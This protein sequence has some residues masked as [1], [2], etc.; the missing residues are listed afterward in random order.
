MARFAA[1]AA[2]ADERDSRRRLSAKERTPPLGGCLQAV[3]S[4]YGVVLRFSIGFEY[5]FFC[6]C[7]VVG[8]EP[9]SY[10]LAHFAPFRRR[11]NVILSQS[12]HNRIWCRMCLRMGPGRRA[13]E[14]RC[15]ATHS[16]TLLFPLPIIC[17]FLSCS[18]CDSFWCS[19]WSKTN[20]NVAGNFGSTVTMWH[21]VV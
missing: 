9:S 13:D 1:D 4:E 19:L 12:Q 20:W 6:Q 14:M 15:K 3:P 17:I 5:F 16:M 11:V 18:F 7:A 10:P 2:G 21:T 8:W